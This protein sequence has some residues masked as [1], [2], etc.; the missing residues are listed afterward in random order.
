MQNLEDTKKYRDN[1]FYAFSSR[2][3]GEKKANVFVVFTN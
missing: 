2:M 3:K 1:L